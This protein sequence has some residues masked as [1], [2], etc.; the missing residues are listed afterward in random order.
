MHL[1]DAPARTCARGRPIARELQATAPLTTGGSGAMLHDRAAS[2][3]VLPQRLMTA[4]TESA[5]DS[6]MRSLRSNA[7]TSLPGNLAE[8]PALDRLDLRWNRIVPRPDWLQALEARGCTV[9][10]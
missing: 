6:T 10:E 9:W 4:T 8:L 5:F 2:T 1:R 7:L 3:P